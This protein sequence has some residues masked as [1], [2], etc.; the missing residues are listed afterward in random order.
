MV[1][2]VG[3]QPIIANTRPPELDSY[4]FAAMTC[5]VETLVFFPIML[6]ER[7]G[8]KKSLKNNPDNRLELESLLHGWKK[9]KPLLLYLGINFGIAQILFFLGYQLAGAINGALAQK[10]TVIFSLLFGFLINKEKIKRTQVIFSFLLLFGLTLAIT[11]GSF[12]L[13]E[14]N[15]G[16]VIMLITATLW[17]LAHAI[18]KPIFGKKEAT[19]IQMVFVRN[20]LSGAILIST[21]F[22]FY[23]IENIGLLFVPINIF[24]YIIM[25]IV[26]GFDLFCWYKVLSFFDVSKASVLAAPTPII[27]ALFAIFLG[28]IFTIFHLIGSTII[29]VSIYFIV[30][31]KGSASENSQ[32]KQNE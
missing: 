15:V 32:S 23:P 26:Y 31:D 16:V 19:P 9:H 8:I 4:I 24:Y 5:I 25:G 30:R 11:Q 6:F 2:L 17:M 20:L 22:I 1:V 21:Y 18:T 27:T 3:L 10:T 28:E 12:N 29:I 7:K 14:F 13:L